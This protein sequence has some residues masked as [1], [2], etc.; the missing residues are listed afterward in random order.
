M[1]RGKFCIRRLKFLY[2]YF[3]SLCLFGM[4]D[5]LMSIFYC[6]Y[7]LSIEEYNCHL[8]LPD[9]MGTVVMLIL[10][11]GVLKLH[12]DLNNCLHRIFYFSSL[13]LQIAVSSLVPISQCL[14]YYGHLKHQEWSISALINFDGLY[15]TPLSEAHDI[16]LF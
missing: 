2:S 8:M 14:R 15:T 6:C 7:I 11:L 12:E 10:I 1:V 13:L 4:S 5:G 3:F 9:L 16:Y